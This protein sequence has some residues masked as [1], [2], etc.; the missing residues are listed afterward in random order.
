MGD[1]PRAEDVP[2]YVTAALDELAV[3]DQA[4]PRARA[5]GAAFII[6]GVSGWTL[7]ATATTSALVV[8]LVGPAVHLTC[9]VLIALGVRALLLFTT[10][11]QDADRHRRRIAEVADRWQ[12]LQIPVTTPVTYPPDTDVRLTVAAASTNPTVVSGS[13]IVAKGVLL[14]TKEAEDD[15]ASR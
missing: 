4:M 6:G 2:R 3:A 14:H 10:D 7:F 9:F 11:R 12:R 5:V 13:S 15:T 8:K 1:R